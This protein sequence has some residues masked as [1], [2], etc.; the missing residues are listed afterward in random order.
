[1]RI[2]QKSDNV[3]PWSGVRVLISC[4][5]SV[6]GYLVTVMV[7]H[8]DHQHSHMQAVRWQQS[9]RVPAVNRAI[10]HLRQVFYN[11]AATSQGGQLSRAAL[12]QR[13][14]QLIALEAKLNDANVVF[15]SAAVPKA[16]AQMIHDI[17]QD[18]SDARS[19]TQCDEKIAQDQKMLNRQ[20]AQ[21]MVEEA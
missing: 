16:E 18:M 1:M 20:F 3:Q 10:A 21:T 2:Q 6:L 15:V 13:E 9:Q 7:D 11:T 14:D 19:A 17:E 4:V 8:F 12:D 5:I